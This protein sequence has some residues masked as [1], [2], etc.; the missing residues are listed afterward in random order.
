MQTK[1]NPVTEPSPIRQL[2]E[3]PGQ[4]A[5]MA[6]MPLVKT[7]LPP[8]CKECRVEN[9]FHAWF[10]QHLTP[11]FNWLIHFTGTVNIPAGKRAV[12]EL[13]TATIFVPSGERARLRMYTS[14]GF[15][16]SN[17]DFV[18]THQGQ[19]GGREVL[20]ATHSVRVYSDHSI[21]FNVNRDNAQTEG[22]AFICISGYFIDM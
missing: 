19:V 3:K 7:H 11:S 16:S 5:A 9:A 1:K 20:V 18:L 15:A 14:L 2:V 4:P 21:E 8:Q 10:D 17:L 6:S 22:D 13:V 12:I